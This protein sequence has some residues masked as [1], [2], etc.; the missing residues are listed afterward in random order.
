MLSFIQTNLEVNNLQIRC[1]FTIRLKRLK[2]RAPDFRGPKILRVRT[3][4]S[5]FV[6]NCICIFVLVQR[7]F[8]YHA[9]NKK[10]L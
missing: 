9:A 4:V 1:G 5:I 6:S 10:A 7:T 2:T 8:F 3:I